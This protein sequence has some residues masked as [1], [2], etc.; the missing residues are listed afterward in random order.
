MIRPVWM[1]AV[2]LA[3]LFTTERAPAEEAVVIDPQIEWVH[4][5][6]TPPMGFIEPL[7]CGGSRFL[8]GEPGR[9]L[10][11]NAAYPQFIETQRTPLLQ[12]TYRAVGIR[13]ASVCRPVITFFGSGEGWVPVLFEGDL[14]S[15]GRVRTVTIDIRDRLPEDRRTPR[16]LKQLNLRLSS[17]A[18]CAGSFDLIDLRFVPAPRAP[19]LPETAPVPATIRVVDMDGN[20]IEGATVRLDPYLREPRVEAR[21]DADGRATLLS[22]HPQGRRAALVT[23]DGY[24]SMSFNN[25][26][27][28]DAGGELTARLVPAQTGSGVIVGED[29]RPI[30]GAVGTLTVHGFAWENNRLGHPRVRYNLRVRTD[31]AG[32]WST[33]PLPAMPGVSVRVRWVHPAYDDWAMSFPQGGPTTG[34]MTSLGPLRERTK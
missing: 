13:T 15:D 3:L 18:G 23:H 22:P 9:D 14:V 19:S 21:T 27:D 4:R 10:D 28:L 2:A 26:A 11:A 24:L 5:C 7:E 29:G 17:E 32:A 30:A 20:P 34:R 6:A 12:L 31:E 33:D 1:M 16:M 25:L 8:I